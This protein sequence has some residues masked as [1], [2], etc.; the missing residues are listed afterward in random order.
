[1]QVDATQKALFAAALDKV[2]AV[3]TDAAAK[4][5]VSDDPYI[6]PQARRLSPVQ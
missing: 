4:H 1:M 3:N 5:V 2:V 6:R